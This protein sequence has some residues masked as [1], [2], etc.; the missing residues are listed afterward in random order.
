MAKKPLIK[1]VTPKKARKNAEHTDDILGQPYAHLF[2][3]GDIRGKSNEY[4]TMLYMTA[5]DKILEQG[6]PC[7][8]RPRLFF[9]VPINFSF[10]DLEQGNASN[11]MV[12]FINLLNAA[13]GSELETDFL[14]PRIMAQLASRIELFDKGKSPEEVI[15]LTKF[16]EPSA[17]N[18]GI[19]LANIAENRTFGYVANEFWSDRGNSS[20]LVKALKAQ[21]YNVR[22]YR[23]LPKDY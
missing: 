16:K 6:R 19:V 11:K 10:R 14:S 20:N 17:D 4:L 18:Y 3:L 1:L 9:G 15:K 2:F 5:H 8:F 13:S 21:D 22:A 12:E 7:S 23:S